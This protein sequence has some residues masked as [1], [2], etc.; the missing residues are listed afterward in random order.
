M[1]GND[2]GSKNDGQEITRVSRRNVIGLTTG[3]A[4]LGVGAVY[5]L[6]SLTGSARAQITVEVDDETVELSDDEE[7]TGISLTG[8]VEASYNTGSATATSA[9]M[10]V[11]YGDTGGVEGVGGNEYY[12]Y[13][14][15]DPDADEITQDVAT[16]L[17]IPP[18]M[19]DPDPGESVETEF[20]VDVMF[21]VDDDNDQEIVEAI[22]SD[23][24][25]IRIERE[26]DDSE[27]EN[28]DDDDDNDDNDGDDEP[29]SAT[30]TG[31]FEFEVEVD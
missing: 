24:A 14:D 23:T 13:D 22:S 16:S 25:T 30:V 2:G 18:E 15:V 21:Q 20:F 19:A 31:S 8:S 10:T 7:V 29:A 1:T 9:G 28:D 17:S 4:A 27:E 26:A 6:S 12:P 5:G 11:M 3:A